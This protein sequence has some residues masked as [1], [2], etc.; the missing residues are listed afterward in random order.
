MG[1]S[2]NTKMSGSWVAIDDILPIGLLI[3][4]EEYHQSKVITITEDSERWNFDSETLEQE[5]LPEFIE[6]KRHYLSP[7][8]EELEY[9]EQDF[10]STRTSDSETSHL[11]TKSDFGS[12]G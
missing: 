7:V 2:Q 4:E 11:S 5:W 1:E 8:F 3:Q 12:T 9:E 6:L 10:S